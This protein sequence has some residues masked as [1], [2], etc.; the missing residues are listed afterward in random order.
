[1]LDRLL[2][3]FRNPGIKAFT[4][5]CRLDRY[6]PVKFGR[7]PEIEFSRIRTE[8]LQSFFSAKLKI[9]FDSCFE[10][11]FQVIDRL[12]KKS[13]GSRVDHSAMKHVDTGI[14]FDQGDIVLNEMVPPL[15]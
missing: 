15:P 10:F 4:G 5:F 13:V 1:M 11:L 14:V 8:G 12:S 7:D 9:I 2:K 3:M 6:V